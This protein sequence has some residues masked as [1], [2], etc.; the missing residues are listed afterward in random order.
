MQEQRP[1]RRNVGWGRVA[2]HSSHS[3]ISVGMGHLVDRLW[4]PS[5]PMLCCLLQ[6]VSWDAWKPNGPLM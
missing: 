6:C 2:V 4:V 5:K 1:L 3:S